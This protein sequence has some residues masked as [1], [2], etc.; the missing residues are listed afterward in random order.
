MTEG[1]SDGDRLTARDADHLTGSPQIATSRT[2]A[3][4]NPATLE[5]GRTT[6]GLSA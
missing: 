2:P 6:S 3:M 5:H 4:L 1:T